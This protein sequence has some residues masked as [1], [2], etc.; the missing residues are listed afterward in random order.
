MSPP[1]LH[2][3]RILVIDDDPDTL[4]ALDDLLSATGATV[5]TARSAD[6]AI[7]SFTDQRPDLILSG[8]SM[9][10]GDGY[11]LIRRV[12]ART[13]FDDAITPAIALTAHTSHTEQARALLAGFQAHLPKPINA[14][15]LLSKIHQFVGRPNQALKAER[16]ANE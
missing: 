16:A 6:E 14:V 4:S 1:I 9:P 15:T 11:Q 12:R 13:R 8:I 10:H 7:A 2:G 3:T 5:V